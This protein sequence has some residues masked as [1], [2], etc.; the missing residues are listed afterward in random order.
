MKQPISVKPEPRKAQSNW[1]YQAYFLSQQQRLK[2][3]TN[4]TSEAS[5]PSDE[6]SHHQPA[7]QTEQRDQ[8]IAKMEALA[9]SIGV[10]ITISD[11]SSAPQST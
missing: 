6:P 9:A 11:H 8:I 7:W 4:L 2:S 1:S 10:R 3:V 5:A